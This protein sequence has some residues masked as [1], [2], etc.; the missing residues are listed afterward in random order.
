[1]TR[2]SIS[3]ASCA[4][5]TDVYENNVKKLEIKSA[6]VTAFECVLFDLIMSK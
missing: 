4:N 5:N 6:A 3:S 1:M 2:V